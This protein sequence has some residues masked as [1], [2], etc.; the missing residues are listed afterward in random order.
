MINLSEEK[1]KG[2]KIEEI[3]HEDDREDFFSKCEHMKGKLQSE[4]IITLRVMKGH[5]FAFYR[6]TF[7]LISGD[8]EV[9]GYIISFEE[10]KGF[11]SSHGKSEKGWIDIEEQEKKEEF[12]CNVFHG[13]QDAILIHDSEG[14]IVSYNKKAIELLGVTF[15]E[16]ASISHFKHFTP[17]EM[18]IDVGYKYFTD[19]LNGNDQSFTW[20]LERPDGFIMD[21]EVFLTRIDKMG[22]DVVLATISDITDKKKIEDSLKNSEKRYR[23]LVEYSPDGIVIHRDGIIKY[24]NPEGVRIFGGESAVDILGT[25]VLRFFPA[26]THKSIKE[27]L[28]SLYDSHE[29]MELMEGRMVKLD[30]SEIFVEFA[31]IPFNL[32]GKVAVQAVIRDITEKKEQEEYIKYLALHDTLTKLPNR[33]LLNERISKSFERRKRDGKKNAV[34]YMD[35]D[36]F[37]PVNDTLGHDA[38]DIA[39]KEIAER[40]EKAVRASDTAARIGGDEF[41]ILLEGVKDREEIELVSARIIKAV[42]EPIVINGHS[43]HVGAS[44]GISVYPDDCEEMPKLVTLADKAMYHAKETGKNRY[45]FFSDMP[46]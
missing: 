18:N 16:M 38:G 28:K 41:V 30:G 5:S 6:L 33:D 37:K 25:D 42:N 4:D 36:G 27:R 2:M 32:D 7:S 34:I 46:D 24:I 45:I 23:Q 8:S 13:I 31:A 40:L 20:Q 35:L 3:V 22:E 9:E 26:D 29:A 11:D 17:E 43:F 21:V 19:A 15:E 1:L 44:M 12:L 39:L 14:N 10:K